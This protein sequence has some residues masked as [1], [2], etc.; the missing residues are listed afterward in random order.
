MTH[1]SSPRTP[2]FG[3]I[4]GL[5][6]RATPEFSLALFRRM[7]LTR[8]F[9]TRA[10]Q[11]QADQDVRTL[12]YL[13]LGEEAISAGISMHAEG[14]WV[15][16]QHRGHGTYL[17]FGGNMERLIDELLGMPSGCSSGMGGSPPIHDMEKGIVGHSGL[18]GDQVPVA[19]GMAMAGEA[20][21]VVTFFGD[22]AAEEDYVLASLGTAASRKLPI[23]FVC[24]DND[25]SVLTPTRDRRGW[26]LAQ[27]ARGFGLEAVDIADDPW[28][29]AHW[30]ETLMVR[31]PALI[32]VRTCRDVW[33]VGIGSDGAP[34]WNRFDLV[35]EKLAALGLGEQAAR[36][37]AEA[38]D[39]VEAKWQERL[40]IRSAS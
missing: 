16:G 33:H 28:L 34:E 38:R 17:S 25:L 29:V 7:A 36:I 37:E 15:L 35:R 2:N 12:I 21:K 6:E 24:E 32:N 13:C 14:A 30:A 18:I 1:S 11:A 31:L 40:R 9:E 5:A 8:A 39:L 23:L 27:V 26:D 10:R 20:R 3:A 19:V 4:P 22:G